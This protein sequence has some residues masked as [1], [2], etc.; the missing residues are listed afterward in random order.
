[1][2]MNGCVRALLL[3]TLVGGA[4]ACDVV[5]AR[6]DSPLALEPAGVT[7]AV[8][9]PTDGD[10]IAAAELHGAGIFTRV[11]ASD[12]PVGG[13]LWIAAWAD[14][15]DAPFFESVRTVTDQKV[16]LTTHIRPDGWLDVR[17]VRI[18]GQVRDAAGATLA[19][20]T[21]QIRIE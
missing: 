11:E 7:I 18:T 10:A 20:D 13:E 5:R 19:A 1:M 16:V 15:G 4:S 3:S 8:V 9:Q 12:S 21:V 6:P 2:A 14:D 17:Q